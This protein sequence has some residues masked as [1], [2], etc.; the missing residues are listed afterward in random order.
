MKTIGVLGGLGPQATMDF[1]RRIHEVS[2]QH[3]PA[4]ENSG[5]PPMIVYYC[6]F[7]P[8]LVDQNSRPVMPVQPNPAFL[9]AAKELGS[10]ADFLVITA[11]G[12]HVFQ[13]EIEAA[14]GQKVLSM[15]DVVLAKLQQ[16]G[17]QKVGL[18]AL[19]EPRIYMQALDQMGTKYVTLETEQRERLDWAIMRVMEGMDGEAEQ[20][21]AEA[22][23]GQL[24]D[25]GTEGI[26]L[27]CTEIPLLLTSASDEQTLINPAELLAEATV[28]Y[29][30]N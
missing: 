16:L 23:I 13:E 15:I 9:Q 21:V 28:K 12:P 20:R 7:P 11:N 1:E 24:K 17:W 3:I 18:L 30:M 29:A 6:R 8:V 2:Q 25:Q 14:A 22:A 5:Y 10:L 4:K 27:G 19:G 26:I